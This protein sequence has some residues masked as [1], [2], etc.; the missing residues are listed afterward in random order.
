MDYCVEISVNCFFSFSLFR[1]HPIYHRFAA[2]DNSHLIYSYCIV[3]ILF[4]VIIIIILFNVWLLL[5]CAEKTWFL[6]I[7]LFFLQNCMYFP[8]R[9]RCCVCHATLRCHKKSNIFSPLDRIIYLCIVSYKLHVRNATQ[10]DV[11]NIHASILPPQSWEILSLKYV[12][13]RL[14]SYVKSTTEAC[15]YS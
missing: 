14:N 9:I 10:S 3:C 13:I 5:L 6:F 11:T 1:E 2:N 4:L 8:L 7:Y 12:L 15:I